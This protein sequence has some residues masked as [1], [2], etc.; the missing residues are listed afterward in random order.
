ML[1]IEKICFECKQPFH[2]SKTEHTRGRAKFCS[3]SCSSSHNLRVYYAKIN[4]PNVTCAFCGKAFYKNASQQ[5]SARTQTFFCCREHKDIGQRLENGLTIIHPPH[6]NNGQRNYRK[7]A[8]RNHLPQC[9]HC[10]WSE[11]PEV[12]VV[13]HKDRDRT[14]NHPS[15]LEILCSRCHD[16]HHFKEKTGKWGRVSGAP[17]I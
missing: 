2:A 8:F 12:L 13:H 17:E 5:K 3:L 11:Y 15:N 16:I 6:Y 14:H 4:K 9:A 10:K 7:I 1:T